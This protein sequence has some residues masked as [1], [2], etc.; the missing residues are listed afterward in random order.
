M[1][2]S[3]KASANGSC[4]NWRQSLLDFRCAAGTHCCGSGTLLASGRP[5]L[6]T[7]GLP[8]SSP[9]T[10][11]PKTL[12][13]LRA[14]TLGFTTWIFGNTSGVSPGE[15]VTVWAEPFA[16]L[17]AAGSSAQ[18]PIHL[19]LFLVSSPRAFPRA[20]GCPPCARGVDHRLTSDVKTGFSGMDLGMLEW[21]HDWDSRL[22]GLSPVR[23]RAG[24]FPA[25]RKVPHLELGRE[26]GGNLDVV[27]DLPGG[28]VGV[29]IAEGCEEPEFRDCD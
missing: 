22:S 3:R 14:G 10:C 6:H 12:L 8:D 27:R 5:G 2:I 21:W 1:I 13:L 19:W 4:K 25:G 16:F 23:R 9:L 11:G 24:T 26:S 15:S 20:Q 18:S 7:R 29:R 28:D 17:Q